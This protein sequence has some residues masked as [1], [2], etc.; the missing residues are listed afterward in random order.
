MDSLIETSQTE[1]SEQMN[2]ILLT[3]LAAI[4]LGQ[5][6]QYGNGALI[7]SSLVVLTLAIVFSALSIAAPRLHLPRISPTLVWA[8]LLSGLLLQII[9]LIVISPVYFG[10]PEFQNRRWQFQGLIG[11]GG[12]CALLSLIPE[13]WLAPVLRKIALG[14]VFLCMFLAGVWVIKASPSP[15]IDVFMF[16]QT[17]A[18]ALMNNQNPYELSEPNIYGD[19]SFYGPELVKNGRM[20]IG[21]PYPPYSIYL[22]SLG[23]FIAGD[24]RYSHIIAILMTAFLITRFS[25]SRYS[26]LGSFLFLFTPRVFFVLEQSWTE[27]LVLLMATLTIWVSIRHPK[28]TFVALG[29]LFASKQY[30]L[31][32][33]PLSILLLK[34]GS[35]C[36]NWIKPAITTIVTAFVVTAP[37][38]FANLQKFIWDVGLAQFY[39]V[40]RYDALSFLAAFALTTG[41]IPSQLI[42]FA[43]L[44]IAF[45]FVFKYVH[46]TPYGFAAAMAFCLIMFFAFSKQAFCNYYFLV[47]GLF[48]SSLA[49]VPLKFQG[50]ETSKNQQKIAN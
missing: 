26:L 43:I 33:F 22:S 37:L 17:S 28:W 6:I 25:R 24:V 3:G 50:E 23:Y 20:T 19:L 45:V 32:L 10:I 36:K 14:F 2:R 18:S 12:F 13:K 34:N 1:N 7:K 9:E 31:L 35:S 21:N 4:A 46:H 11:L 38:A 42:S 16:H 15:I 29:L 5:A 48:A 8:I 30:M 40:F 49:A 39:Q 27:P 44:A 47:V 41:K